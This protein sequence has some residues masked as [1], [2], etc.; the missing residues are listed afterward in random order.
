MTNALP[1]DIRVRLADRADVP[2]I[3]RLLADDVLGATRELPGEP[4]AEAYWNAFDAMSAQGGTE[5]YVADAD[6]EIVGCL[7]LNVIHGLSRVGMTR[8]LIEGVRVSSRCRGRRIGEA[9]MTAA[10]DRARALGCRVVQ[11]TTDRTRVDAHRFYERL[12]FEATHVGMKLTL[13]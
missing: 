8:G 5:L 6:G 9:M 12:G 4:L 7:Q 3:V 2:A 10:I 1:S 13:A 11:L